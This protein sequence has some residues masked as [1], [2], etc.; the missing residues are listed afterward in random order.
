MNGQGEESDV[1]D[2]VAHPILDTRAQFAIERALHWTSGLIVLRS[3]LAHLV[4]SPLYNS[5]QCAITL[6]A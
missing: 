3:F 6:K 5:R 4:G 2:N 1:L